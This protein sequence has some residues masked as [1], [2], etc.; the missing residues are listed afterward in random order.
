M[1]TLITILVVAFSAT[2][3]ADE[4]DIAADI[5]KDWSKPK[6]NGRY[7]IKPPTINDS[8]TFKYLDVYK[9]QPTNCY[10]V[11]DV[12]GRQVLKCQ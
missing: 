7:M 5:I 12:W 4:W 8:D 11:T 3:F 9:S 2:S 10:V 6:Y 1:K